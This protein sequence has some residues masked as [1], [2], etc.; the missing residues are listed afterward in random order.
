MNNEFLETRIK[1]LNLSHDQIINLLIE[2]VSNTPTETARFDS[3]LKSKAL[4][5]LDLAELIEKDKTTYVLFKDTNVFLKK[6]AKDRDMSPTE[7]L[8]LIINSLAFMSNDTS[9][10]LAKYGYIN[11]TSSSDQGTPA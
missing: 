11:S 6:W 3:F 5:K 1:L 9:S 2:W 7:A 8:N 4:S 10:S